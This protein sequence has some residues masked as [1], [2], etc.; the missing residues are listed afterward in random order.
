MSRA[1]TL[2]E[3]MAALALCALLLVSIGMVIASLPIEQHVEHH[4]ARSWDPII[5]RDFRQAERYEQPTPQTLILTQG[6]AS[7]NAERIEYRVEVLNTTHW[8]VR[9]ATGTNTPKKTLLAKDTKAIRLLSVGDEDAPPELLDAKG[10]IPRAFRFSLVSS[11]PAGRDRDLLV[12]RRSAPT[13]QPK[14]R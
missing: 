4:E 11:E 8:L 13:P 14:Q 1:F 10:V 9:L 12:G 3:L 5:L 2:I 6:Q 7:L